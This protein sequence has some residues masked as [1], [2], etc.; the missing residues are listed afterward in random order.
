MTFG[1]P[2]SE[3]NTVNVGANIEHTTFDLGNNPST[4]VIDF[5]NTAGDEFLTLKLKSSWSSDSRNRRFLPDTGS[6][7]R[8]TA[9]LAIPGGD[10]TY[11]Q[12]SLRHQRFF[13]LPRDFVFVLEGEIGYGDGYGDTE[14]FP[15]TENFY[16]GGIRSVRGFESNTL[17]PRDSKMNHS[18]VTPCWSAMRN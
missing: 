2:I 9:E 16:A 4:E 17:G 10:L 14:E 15:L 7:S 8:I 12:V 18:V 5:Q 13:S 3:F 6:L 1:I 11:Y